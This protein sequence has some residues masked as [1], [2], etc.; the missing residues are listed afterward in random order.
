M[1]DCLRRSKLELR[2]LRNGLNIDPR[3][4]GGV[5]SVQCSAQTPKVLTKWAGGRAVRPLGRPGTAAS[6]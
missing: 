1:R 6:W 5:N 4:S 3:S 2:G